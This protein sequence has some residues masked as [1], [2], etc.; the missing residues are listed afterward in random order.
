MERWDLDFSLRAEEVEKAERYSGITGVACPRRMD[1]GRGKCWEVRWGYSVMQN[2]GVWKPG[3]DTLVV[4][5]RKL[6][7][8][9]V[10]QIK[11]F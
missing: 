8:K 1:G 11:V 7:K 6:P 9:Q 3:Q 5:K 10:L 2:W 4:G